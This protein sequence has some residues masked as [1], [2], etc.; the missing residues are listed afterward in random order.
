MTG[1]SNKEG[2]QFQFFPSCAC[3]LKLDVL[4]SLV[5]KKKFE[6]IMPMIQWLSGYGL[7]NSIYNTIFRSSHLIRNF[8]ELSMSVFYECFPKDK[9]RYIRHNEVWPLHTLNSRPRPL[10]RV[11]YSI[12]FRLLLRNLYAWIH[13]NSSWKY[14]QAFRI[15]SSLDWISDKYTSFY[16]RFYFEEADNDVR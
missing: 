3:C 11:H 10:G 16:R 5:K 2:D 7:K 1:S 6:M 13:I 14:F 4:S 15:I 8:A 12:F 9:H